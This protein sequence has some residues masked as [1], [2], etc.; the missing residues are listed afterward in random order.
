MMN[1]PECWKNLRG[2]YEEDR[3]RRMLALDGGGIRV[4][5][6]LGILEKIEALVAGDS[7][8][9]L[10]DYFDYIAGTS[11]GAIIAAGLARG[12]T[13]G[14]IIN[15][16]RS[17]GPHMFEHARLIDRLKNF[18]TADPLAAQLQE[19]FG[20]DTNLEPPNLKCLLLIVTR[21]LITNSPWAISSNPEAKYNDVNR[22]HCNLKIPLWQLMR[23]STAAPVFFPPE[24]FHW[25]P[26]NPS[27]AFV[28]V[29]G[30][31][32]PHNNPA[33]LL[34]R[35][36]TEPAYRLNWKLGERNLFLVS[37]G[38]G[39]A[40][41]LSGVTAVPDMNIISTVAA[42]PG[43]L[44]YGV[45][46]DQDIN[47]RIIGRC[48]YGDLLDREILDLVPR[49]VVA[50]GIIEEQL[51]APG[52]P[53]TTD[54]GRDFLYARYNADLSRRGLDLL[55][56]TNIASATIQKMDATDNIDNLLEIGRAAGKSAQ[57][58]HFG[59]FI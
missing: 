15:F 7:T 11:T 59:T 38:A 35:M 52:V 12:M 27:R 22:K 10:C 20:F 34:Y 19:V 58:A 24:I 32:T 47:C 55:G 56:F 13:T 25:D 2:R 49:E 8:R 26:D 6:T 45:Q 39:M 51:T 17:A 36:A 23:A 37:V 14:E 16:F 4:F 3:P 57:T 30:G 53:L 1:N 28:F 44:M 9:K 54:L 31:L 46:V 42:V 18:Y 40:G 33:F 5:L 43:E 29:D 50:G 41:S 48:A 21:N